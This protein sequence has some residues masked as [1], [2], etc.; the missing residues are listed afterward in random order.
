[1]NSLNIIPGKLPC[2]PSRSRQQG[3]TLFTALIFLIMLTLLG[4]NAA[5]ISILEERM[6]GNARNR[7]LA[8]QAAEAALA[9]ARDNLNQGN[10]I[11][12]KYICNWFQTDGSTQP[13]PP[14]GLL[15]N[16]PNRPITA[17]YW[18]PAPADCP[19]TTATCYHWGT[20]NNSPNAINPG[21]DL[22]LNPDSAVN[23]GLQPLFV[24]EKVANNKKYRI[25]ARGTGG[26]GSS[27]VILQAMF[28]TDSI[29]T[30]P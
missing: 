8:F 12:G 5:Q 19:E 17:S 18:N 7:D 14:N 2:S 28:S 13:N 11:N 29:P 15:S 25:T 23:A 6:A 26:D 4:A 27:I 22:Q 30:C 24:V 10:Q 21:L 20:A 3:V 16:V 1:M 9:Y